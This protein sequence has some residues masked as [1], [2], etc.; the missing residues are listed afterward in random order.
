M[1]HPDLENIEIMDQKEYL[2]FMG[3]MTLLAHTFTLCLLK[4]PD[5]NNI[6]D[7][8]D[9]KRL[10]N[11]AVMYKNVSEH[12]NRTNGSTITGQVQRLILLG[13]HD[14]DESLMAQKNQRI[15]GN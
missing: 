10:Q 7:K 1:N 9:A 3:N 12:L 8:D 2:R 11:V 5:L 6:A 14:K 15:K 13:R 4:Y